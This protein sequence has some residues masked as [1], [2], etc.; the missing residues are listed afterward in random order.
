MRNSAEPHPANLG[1]T[2]AF[3]G[4]SRKAWAGVACASA[5]WSLCSGS[6]YPAL[7]RASITCFHNRV[8]S[9]FDN[10]F[11]EPQNY[12]HRMLNRV[13]RAALS[14]ALRLVCEF[15]AEHTT[16]GDRC[17]NPQ[18]RFRGETCIAGADLTHNSDLHILKFPKGISYQRI[19]NS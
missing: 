7:R 4:E 15:P 10:G 19:S 18:A 6:A 1:S 3:P 9:E 14:L 16:W 17:P 11:Y 5:D 8:S 13:M 2:P 12:E